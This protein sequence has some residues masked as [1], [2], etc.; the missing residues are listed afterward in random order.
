MDLS[1]VEQRPYVKFAFLPLLAKI[2]V[3]VMPSYEK[4]CRLDG[5]S[6]VDA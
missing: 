3:S 1:K 6:N 2:I 5:G 4:N